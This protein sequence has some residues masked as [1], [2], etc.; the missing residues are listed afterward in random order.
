MS[1]K[2]A[3]IP[4][5]NLNTLKQT[6]IYLR[7]LHDYA[8]RRPSFETS[9]SDSYYIFIFQ[10][11]GESR[12]MVDF[13]EA[14]LM[15]PCVYFIAP[16]QVHHFISS[17]D[18]SGWIIAADPLLIDQS[19]RDVLEKEYA[20]QKPAG[21]DGPLNDPFEHCLK[22]LSDLLDNKSNNR[23]QASILSHMVSVCIGLFISILP[24][25]TNQ[26]HPSRGL[27]LN[28]QFRILLRAR[29]STEK[30][31]SGYAAL[32]H[33]S[34]SYLNECV[35]AASGRPVS[36][37]ILQQIVLEAKRLLAYS[38]FD[39]KEIAYRLGYADDTYFIRL[40]KKSTGV[41]PAAFRKTT[42]FRPAFT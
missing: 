1:K 41:S 5:Y 31:P 22:S 7:T 15:G 21:L 18:T 17:K 23:F 38:R 37:W 34:P 25:T 33:V 11:S 24:S 27:Y 6:A 20:N 40:F 16:G 4:I 9:H 39:V 32:L 36:Y 14:V 13:E 10:R 8:S 29:F 2:T 30:K 35:K 26:S 42:A 28:Q 12:L 3:P 19:Y